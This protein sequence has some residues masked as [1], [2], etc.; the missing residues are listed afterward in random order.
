MILG[1]KNRTENWKTAQ[2]FGRMSSQEIARFANHLLK[3]YCESTDCAA[4]NLQSSQVKLDLFWVGMRDYLYQTGKKQRECV[5]DF[6]E[7]YIRLFPNLHQDI[8]NSQLFR[9]AGRGKY[10]VP[11]T[12]SKAELFTNLSKTEIDIV[13]ES[14]NHLFIGEAKYKSAQNNPTFD[15]KGKY[16]L[17]HQLM[18]QYVTATIL[19]E[20]RRQKKIIIPF[21]VGEDTGKLK[22]KHQVRFMRK[23][24]DLK[25][26]NILT[27]CQ[28]EQL[29][30]IHCS[31]E[32][33]SRG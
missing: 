27:W 32:D 7:R 19:I 30:G 21:I 22:S 5:N 3:S 15:A 6:A 2:T 24:Y 17:V 23:F 8:I 9:G 10:E 14:P 26:S 31:D 13:I 11:T 18:R 1:I 29:A 28:V 16:V 12:E 33:I 20:M 25:E 4:P